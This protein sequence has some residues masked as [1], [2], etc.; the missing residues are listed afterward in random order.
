MFLKKDTC[1]CFLPPA[2]LFGNVPIISN[3]AR[4]IFDSMTSSPKLKDWLALFFCLMIYSAI[5]IPFGFKFGLLRWQLWQESLGSSLKMLMTLFLMPSRGEEL[6]FRVVALP[7]PTEPNLFLSTTGAMGL[8]LMLFVLY[9]PINAMFF[10]PMGKSVFC[11][12]IFLC[13]AALLGGIATMLYWQ[14][15]SLW[16]IAIFHWLVVVVWLMALG[17]QAQLINVPSKTYQ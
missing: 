6:V 12:P 2:R 5:A 11:K 8:S 17:G 9:H 16:L 10:Y 1:T 3:T 14:T 4:R 13:L 7:Y 15:G